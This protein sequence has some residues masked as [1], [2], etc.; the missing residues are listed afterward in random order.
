MT[1]TQRGFSYIVEPAD[2]IYKSD[3]ISRSSSD[4]RNKSALLLQE[5]K[6]LNERY[7]SLSPS[8]QPKTDKPDDSCSCRLSIPRQQVRYEVTYKA[9]SL[10]WPCTYCTD[11]TVIGA[12]MRGHA[13]ASKIYFIYL[14]VQRLTFKYRWKIYLKKSFWNT[15]SVAQAIL[16]KI[17]DV[18]W[19]EGGWELHFFLQL[20]PHLSTWARGQIHYNDEAVCLT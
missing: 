11:C 1:P 10:P 20:W 12:C 13:D 9:E 14:V 6:L 7:L 2:F 18:F 4:R 19:G 17:M 5:P 3:P 15:N 8:F 16:C